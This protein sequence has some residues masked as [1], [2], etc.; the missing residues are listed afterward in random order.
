MSETPNLIPFI[1]EEGQATN[2]EPLIVSTSH[3]ELEIDSNTL[4][5]IAIIAL[6]VAVS[7]G[8]ALVF[9]ILMGTDFE[10]SA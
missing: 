10:R 6:A 7:T 8:G 2:L 1:E 5:S 4:L 9:A 3:K